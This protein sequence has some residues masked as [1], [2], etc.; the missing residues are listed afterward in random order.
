MVSAGPLAFELSVF[1]AG[2]KI[3]VSYSTAVL[4]V[5]IDIQVV[6]YRYCFRFV[7]SRTIRIYVPDQLPLSDI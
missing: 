1:L 2:I 5:W 4:F 7:S 3:R 6:E